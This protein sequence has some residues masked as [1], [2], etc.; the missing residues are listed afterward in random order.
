MNRDVHLVS[1]ALL[2]WGLGEGLFLH[3]QPAYIERLGA[4]PGQVGSLLS[5]T[6]AVTTTSFL[7]A[8]VLANRLP[9]K[10]IMIG[11]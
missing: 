1:V 8:G 6:A 2:L 10:W 5:A 7:P 3:V 11:G 9:R 4:T